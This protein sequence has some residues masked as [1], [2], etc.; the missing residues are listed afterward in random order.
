MNHE[1]ASELLQRCIRPLYGYCLRRCAS[2]QDAEDA[3]QEILL[4]TWQMLQ[5][6]DVQQPEHYLWTTARHILANHYRS[7][8]RCS[9]GIPPEAADEQCIDEL[10]CA[11]EDVHRLHDEL[12]RLSRQQREIVVMHYFHRMKQ[13]EIAQVLH[14]PPGTVK[15]HLFEARRE[16]Q[17]KMTQ[18]RNM[19]HL[20]FDPIRFSGFGTEG[21]IGTDGSPWRVFRTSLVQNIAYAC[22]R[23]GRTV[24]D[25]A[26]ALGVSAVYV[27]DE[28]D[29]MT[30]QGYLFCQ[31]GRYRCTILLTELTPDLVRHSDALY[32][33]A[34]AL[35]AP[36][37]ADALDAADAWSS[38]GLICPGQD[39]DHQYA[40][41]ALLPWCIANMP[42]EGTIRFRDVASLRPDGARNLCHATITPPG[43]PQPA[44]AGS[45]EHF[46]GPCWNE[47][48]GVTLW[49]IDTIW[50][51]D[52]IQET[53]QFTEQ[54]ILA[55]LHRLFN[56]EQLSEEDAA[57]LMQRGIL[58]TGD[59]ASLLPV[60]IHGAVLRDR[61][62]EITREV[63]SKHRAALDALLA[64][65]ADALNA[66]TPP[67][68][69]ALRAYL[70]QNIFRDGRFILHCLHHLVDAGRLRTPTEEERLSLHMVIVTA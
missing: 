36:A 50:S 44:L 10:L 42:P 25:I 9:I 22:W 65:Y 26:D 17:S 15:W 47:K 40:L 60:R 7:R 32:A 66:D 27:Q 16:L 57:C 11:Q 34:A 63:F 51:G 5:R 55:L 67:H 56:G 54:R 48:D 53:Y 29:R 49:Q 59:S 23:E 4:K 62:L 2:P 64:P 20:K 21:S 13:A 31:S 38:E 8:A 30:E 37:L 39:A 52:R 14:V 69:R 18:I 3:A 43:T 41:W 24:N 33:S 6:G 58:R 35:I 28:L 68:L 19:E 12:A 1:Q 45:M 46:S 70:L 61:L